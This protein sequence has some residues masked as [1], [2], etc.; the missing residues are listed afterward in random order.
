M[1][2]RSKRSPAHSSP[3]EIRT[4]S[5]TQGS[6]LA[7]RGGSLLLGGLLIA[8]PAALA[9][10]YLDRPA[11][12]A[13]AANQD[14][15]AGLTSS[16]QTA[17]AVATG[18]VGAWL[19]ATREDASLL[20][21]YVTTKTL[22]LPDAATEYR[23]LRL[24]SVTPSA[25]R[26]MASAIVTATVATTVVDGEETK[27]TW[28]PSYFQVLTQLDG[29]AVRVVG[30]PAPIAAPQEPSET[31]ALAYPQTVPSSTGVGQAA[32]AFLTAYLT[33]QGEIARLVAPDAEIFAVTPA[34]YTELRF[35]EL[36]ADVK[37]EGTPANGDRARVLV[38]VSG[39]AASGASLTSTYVLTSVARDGRWEIDSLDLFPAITN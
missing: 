10:H 36:R 1:S 19:S 32:S 21:T 8:G 30:L 33:G 16:E 37:T 13:V 39:T 3:G 34:P 25:E 20:E 18:F 2:I 6:A 5:W 28:V 9:L 7:V 27:T 23:D 17:G 15:Q 11:T 4:S 12:V 35:D 38:T 14:M 22:I 31:L 26:A 24:V 29:T